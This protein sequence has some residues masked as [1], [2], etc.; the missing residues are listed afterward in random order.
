MVNNFSFKKT[1]IDGVIIV[2]TTFFG[3]NRG[4]FAETYNERSFKEAG[5]EYR[6]VQ[7]NQSHSR[8]GVL[9]GLHFQKQYPQTKMIRV[10]DGEIFDVAVDI[11][12]GSP[13]FGKWV[14]VT[15][16][17]DNKR[18]LIIPRG[19]A[20][21]FLVLSDYATICYKC[22]DF[23]HP[24]DEG[25]IIWNDKDIGIEWPA[26][27]EIILSEKDKKHPCLKEL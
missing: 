1:D 22:D 18:Q 8:K 27:D 2:E 24:E 19:F 26:V 16:S 5:I 9:R 11:K 14:G 20:H 7:D 6:F 10:I 15:L 25:G 21:G 4:Y 23:Y 12:K 13:T 3:D 17:S